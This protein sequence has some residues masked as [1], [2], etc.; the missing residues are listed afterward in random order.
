MDAAFL[1]LVIR[2]APLVTRH[3]RSPTSSIFSV[4]VIFRITALLIE[5]AG[6]SNPRFHLLILRH[7]TAQICSAEGTLDSRIRVPTFGVVCFT[8]PSDIVQLEIRIGE[9][10]SDIFLPLKRRVPF[11]I[12][13][14]YCRLGHRVRTKLSFHDRNKQNIIRP[15]FPQF[16]THRDNICAGDGVHRHYRSTHSR[17]SHSRSTYSGSVKQVFRNAGASDA[18]LSRQFSFPV[19]KYAQQQIRRSI[20]V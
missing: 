3:R 7:D 14:D 19:R 2:H 8:L 10:E 1:E 17:S 5:P 11:N 15:L 12:R 4:V 13:K 16:R 18:R 20:V 9:A 6:K